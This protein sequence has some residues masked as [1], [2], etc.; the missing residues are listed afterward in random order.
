MLSEGMLVVVTTPPVFR[1][2]KWAARHSISL[3]NAKLHAIH[4]RGSKVLHLSHMWHMY[5]LQTCNYIGLYWFCIQVKNPWPNVDAHSGVLLQYY[6]ITESNFY[7]VLFGV[8]RAIGV[9]SQVSQKFLHKPHATCCI[10]RRLHVHHGSC[11]AFLPVKRHAFSVVAAECAKE[12]MYQLHATACNV[13]A[14]TL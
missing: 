14:C 7:T 3:L 4:C 13:D 12:C 10:A 2:Q 6:G 11:W 5:G 9:L 1:V 8:S